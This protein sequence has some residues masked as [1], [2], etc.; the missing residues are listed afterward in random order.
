MSSRFSSLPVTHITDSL[1][2]IHL[3]MTSAPPLRCKQVSH[4]FYEALIRNLCFAVETSVRPKV[5]SRLENEFAIQHPP[6]P[7]PSPTRELQTTAD[8]KWHQTC[9][10][11]ERSELWAAQEHMITESQR[12]TSVETFILVRISAVWEQKWSLKLY[13]WIKAFRV[14]CS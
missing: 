8:C 7:P 5:I 11:L 4:G 13:G 10:D 12:E 6:P 14:G 9:W 1:G 3:N 2:K